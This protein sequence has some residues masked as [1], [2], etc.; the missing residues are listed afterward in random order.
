M[1]PARWFSTAFTMLLVPAVLLGCGGDLRWT[2]AW[3][4]AAWFVGYCGY[5]VGW[6]YRNNP[7]LLAERYRVPGTGG[8]DRRDVVFV[9]LIMIGYVAWNIVM[10]LDARRYRWSPPF[11]WIV[12]AIGVLLLG[13]ASFFLFRAFKDNSF[14]SPV[15]RIQDD[16]AHRVV[17]TGVYGIVRHPMYL[18][19]CAMFVGTPLLLGSV[20]GIVVGVALS[21]LLAFRI[22]N[23]ERF[24]VHDLPGYDEYRHKVRYRLA[25]GIW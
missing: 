20:F 13:V 3:L 21:L 17:S 18:G 10:P 7:G 22:V 8:E 12:E 14:L 24:L 4:F 9:T 23:E 25:P 19:A 16:R 15:V 11:P 5:V 1:T 2:E 6:L